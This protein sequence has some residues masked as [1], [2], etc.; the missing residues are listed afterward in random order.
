MRI[1]FIPSSL[2]KAWQLPDE[3]TL[4]GD[5]SPDKERPD[6]LVVA[7]KETDGIGDPTLAAVRVIVDAIDRDTTPR[8]IR[9]WFRIGYSDV[10]VQESERVI[11]PRKPLPAPFFGMIGQSD[12][13][14]KLFAQIQSVAS[15]MATVL[16]RGESGTGKE[17]VARAIHQ[18]SKR[19][20]G[21]FI[22]VN[23]AAIPES[24][25]ED[26]LFGHVRGAFTA[27]RTDRIGKIE[28][29]N[30]GTL[31]LDEI[32]D[33]APALQVKLL[34]VLQ[35]RIIQPLGTST[36]RPVDVR[37]VTATAADLEKLIESGGFREDLYYRLNVVP[38]LL[39]PL[40]D[41]RADIPLLIDFF[42]RKLAERHNLPVPRF[43]EEAMQTLQQ[44]DW[45]GN[46]REL[47]H[48]MERTMV[49]NDDQ[50]IITPELLPDE[51]LKREDLS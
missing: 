11:R 36:S 43:S 50:G 29:A 38:L 3:A 2:R 45:P 8:Q 40:R 4:A 42:S 15:T 12:S 10:V 26:D 24:L 1:S 13:M 37:V 31:F 20:E 9:D 17:L 48:V 51:T 6:I 7:A 46:I 16:I 23:C 5:I 28:A 41:R 47:E 14:R 32:G 35:E 44:R 18:C 39:P 33:M 49:L 30:K 34:R 27:A 22:P 21:P 19:K 25:L